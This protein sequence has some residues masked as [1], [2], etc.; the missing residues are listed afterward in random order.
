MYRTPAT[1]LC[2]CWDFRSSSPVRRARFAVRHRIS[3]SIRTK[4]A[5]KLASYSRVL[6]ASISEAG[7]G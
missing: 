2:V 1:E 6:Y 5:Q 7:L 3:G 4:Y